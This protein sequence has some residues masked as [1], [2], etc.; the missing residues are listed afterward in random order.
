[1]HREEM[2]NDGGGSGCD[3]EGLVVAAVAARYAQTLLQVG[4]GS[5]SG[6]S[7]AKR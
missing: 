3:V 1:M 7:M 4:S 2:V 6:L 5:G